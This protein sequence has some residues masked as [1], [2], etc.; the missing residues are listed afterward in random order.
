[1]STSLAFSLSRMRILLGGIL[2]VLL[3]TLVAKGQPENQIHHEVV[4]EYTTDVW[5][6]TPP[7]YSPTGAP[8]PVLLSLH[9][10]SGIVDDNN[11]NVIINNYSGDVL[12]LTPGRL[13]WRNQ[14][15]TSLPFIVVSPHLK[16]DLSV[17]L[18]NE[19][20]WPTD[21]LD[22]VV[23]YVKDNFN[24]DPNRLYVTGISVGA[25]GSWDYAIDY[26]EKVAAI[27]PLGGKG[28]R[29]K[30]CLVR[31]V[32]IWAHHGQDDGLVPNRFTTD[33]I[34]AILNCSPAGKYIP[35]YNLNNSM[36]HV[37][38]NQIY[39]NRGKYEVYDWL[40]KFEKGDDSNKSPTV[41]TGVDRT[42]VVRPGPMYLSSEY[43]DSD[44][45]IVNVQWTQTNNPGINLGLSDTDSKFLRIGNPQVGNFTFRLTVTD[46]DGA[47]SFDEVNINIVASHARTLTGMTIHTQN[48]ATSTLIGT[49]ADDQVWDLS[50]LGSRINIQTT[51]NASTP[52]TTRVR[53]SINSDQHSKDIGATSGIYTIKDVTAVFGTSGWIALKGT[54]LICATPYSNNVFANEG[55]SLCY[56]VTFTD[57]KNATKYYAMS[58][59]LTNLSSWNSMPDGSGSPPLN[60]S[61]ANQWFIVSSTA[62]VPS[63]LRITGANTRFVLTPTANVT[64]TDSLVAQVHLE[65]KSR[66][67]VS[68]SGG[69]KTFSSVS[70]SST[71]VF[72]NTTSVPGGNIT[73]GN[74]T[75]TGAGPKV[76]TGLNTFVRGDLFVDTGVDLLNVTS[77]G[78]S[79]FYVSGNVTIK[80]SS[81][82]PYVL[83]IAEGYGSQYVNLPGNHAFRGLTVE[84][85]CTMEVVAPTPSTITIGSFTGGGRVDLDPYS[86][87]K[88]NG[89]NLTL[90]N[91]AALNPP[92]GTPRT[93][94]IDL[95]GSILSITANAPSVLNLHPAPG[96]NELKK[97]LLNLPAAHDGLRLM[98]TLK[99]MEGVEI[100]NGK[101]LSNGLL[102]LTSTLTTTAYVAPVVGTA[103][104]EGDV[105]VERM[106]RPGNMYRYLSFP[107]EGFTVADLQEFIPVTGNFEQSSPG[108]SNSPSLYVYNDG[109]ATWVPYPDAA[110]GSA[111][112]LEVGKGYAVYTRG[113]PDKPKK[114]VMR[115]PLRKGTVNFTDLATNPSGSP[116]RGWTLI[117]NPYAAPIR[118]DGAGAPVGWT[119]S[120]IDAGI[121]VRDNELQDFRV[122]D[123]EVGDEELPNSFISSGQSFWIRSINGSPGISVLE[124]AKQPDNSV[125]LYRTQRSDATFLSMTLQRNNRVNTSYI[126][127]NSYGKTSWIKRFDTIK[128]LGDH[129]NISV[130]S[131]EKYAFAIKNLSDTICSQEVPLM[132]ET[133][134][135]GVH[136]IR[137]KGTAF[138]NFIYQLYVVDQFT[139]EKRAVSE[140]DEYV[141]QIT[142]ESASKSPYRFSLIIETSNL[143]QPAIALEDGYLVSS[144]DNVQWMF[145]G[146]DIEGA[147]GSLFLPRENGE[148]SVYTV[149][150]GCSKTSAPFSFRITDVERGG[151]PVKLYPN[152][153]SDHVNITGLTPSSQ[154]DYDI[155]SLNG[156][157]VQSDVL[158]VDDSGEAEIK[159]GSLAQGFYIIRLKGSKQYDFKL[160]IQ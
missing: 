32:P 98:D 70:R 154:I 71:V 96:G 157:S 88:L 85:G 78:N 131:D 44:G 80:T 143:L 42:V 113:F 109:L 24:A 125:Q 36:D 57:D 16:R 75:I 126:K 151:E 50:E 5:I 33:M 102:T 74:L 160:T 29:N 9:G 116:T 137:F 123:G 127:F 82:V 21:L 64:V 35:H 48:A 135:S 89:H 122:T 92:G 65:D 19:Q 76:H 139:G 104:I 79:T 53:W 55:A 144:V 93:G 84:K 149:G 2:L 86:L 11:Y 90:I 56:K 128:R 72:A 105:N 51:A 142:N 159:F 46:D 49:L 28:A 13:I 61:T 120:N 52:A 158:Q 119:H 63:E 147:T 136:S 103:S 58:G 115:G 91:A 153:A 81:T 114:I 26:P 41:L 66:L 140:N 148:Y 23:E 4:G 27:L 133:K 110:Q 45:Q 146:V 8:S 77:G 68:G 107:V 3:A 69:V 15:D 101:L 30:A 40:L 141:F 31:D 25:T 43:F 112:P 10:G 67:V 124:N 108:F 106:I 129:G 59:N 12:H 73:V 99:I 34:D 94:R 83:R 38:W 156:M 22:E 37:V 47:T 54:Y 6:Y 155:T 60:F 95:T 62:S 145:N 138:D 14:W 87:L 7:G 118:W 134:E 121:F 97:L 1:M 20:T 130:L 132:V 117:G 150:K 100:T 17:P 18:V 111:A 39:S 152:P